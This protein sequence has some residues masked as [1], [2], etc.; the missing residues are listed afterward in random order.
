MG[1]ALS[2]EEEEE[3]LEEAYTMSLESPEA[4]KVLNAGTSAPNCQPKHTKEKEDDE[5]EEG[6][7]VIMDQEKAEALSAKHRRG[8]SL[9]ENEQEDRRK[10]QHTNNNQNMSAAQKKMSYVQMARLGY[11]ELVNA[12]IR[13]PRADYKVC[14]IL[15]LGFSWDAKE[16]ELTNLLEW[17]FYHIRWKLWA[18]LLSHSVGND[19]PEPT[20]LF[21]RSEDSTSSALTGN[22][23]SG[24]W[25]E[26]QS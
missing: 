17:L 11:Q 1:N 15:S 7:E 6:Q 22:L 18:P 20:S 24:P 16:I 9:S 26:S 21:E 2:E 19:L 25:I 4:D 10:R 14:S 13:P 8:S 3:L 12:I 5:R 23:S